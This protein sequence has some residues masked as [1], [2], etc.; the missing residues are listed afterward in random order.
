[1]WLTVWLIVTVWLNVTVWLTVCNEM[2][3]G[4]VVDRNNGR[5]DGRSNGEEGCRKVSAAADRASGTISLY[6]S[7]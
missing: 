3:A 7:V 2:A 5:L 6:S 4:T 1:M